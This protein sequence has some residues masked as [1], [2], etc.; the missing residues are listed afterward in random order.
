MRNPVKDEIKTG[1]PKKSIRATPGAL[2]D[3]V[4]YRVM[5]KITGIPGS[6]SL[7]VSSDPFPVWHPVPKT[8][9]MNPGMTKPTV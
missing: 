7:F 2:P 6:L 9:V 8:N 4:H 3:R 5:D 1:P